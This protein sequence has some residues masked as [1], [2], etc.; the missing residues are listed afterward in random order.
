MEELTMKQNSERICFIVIIFFGLFLT[1]YHTAWA[2]H[3][4]SNSYVPNG[5]TPVKAKLNLVE[6]VKKQYAI[7]NDEKYVVKISFI[8]KLTEDADY[9]DQSK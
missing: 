5:I 6:P 9:I 7:I 8:V 3:S 1:I 4:A 2:D